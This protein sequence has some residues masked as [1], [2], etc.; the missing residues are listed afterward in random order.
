MHLQSVSISRSTGRERASIGKR[1]ANVSLDPR[2]THGH[3]WLSRVG[4]TGLCSDSALGPLP[5][6]VFQVLTAHSVQGEAEWDDLGSRKLT[7]AS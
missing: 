4:I 7:K 6:L 5:S 1:L 2:P 3:F